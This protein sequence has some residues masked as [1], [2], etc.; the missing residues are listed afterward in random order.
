MLALLALLALVAC[1]TDVRLG[2]FPDGA[3]RSVDASDDAVDAP[4]V[5]AALDAPALDS[6]CGDT[7][8]SSTDCGRCGH[9]CLGEAVATIPDV[10]HL[11]IDAS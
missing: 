8:S 9:S 1:D 3:T 7:S 2:A 4:T 11:A 10:G 5:D 6:G